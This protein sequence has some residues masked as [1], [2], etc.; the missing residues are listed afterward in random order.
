MTLV[1][2][3]SFP[4]GTGTLLMSLVGVLA[5]YAAC[6]RGSSSAPAPPSEPFVFN[7]PELES[8]PEEEPEVPV[9]AR[10]SG[11]KVA[12]WNVEW[13]HR[14]NGRGNVPRSDEDYAAL[15]RYADM[16]DADVIALQEVDGPEA[17]ARLFDP[18]LYDFAFSSRRSEQLVG[19]A[20]RKG[21]KVEVHPEVTALQIDGN[22]RLRRGVDVSVGEGAQRVRLL[23]VHL[24]S[25]CW[26]T[27]LES[28]EVRRGEDPASC[29]TL[30][31]QSDVLK[32]W[33][34]KRRAAREPFVIL[35]DFNRRLKKGESFWGAIQRDVDD[36]DLSAP[37]TTARSTCK[38]G[39]YPDYI[40]HL[41]L[42]ERVVNRTLLSS[43]TQQI[44]SSEDERRHRDTLSD[45]CPIRVTLFSRP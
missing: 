24:K 30:S 32:A 33:A 3:P 20:Y 9:V 38:G 18:D 19:F 28:A 6:P 17:A 36:V 4:L 5:F 1:K 25:R 34:D 29:R 31:A 42:D 23:G 35:G 7:A 43:F 45:H 11:L 41:V 21:L 15:K 8:E 44:F 37:T 22:R 27:P 26:S 13:L 14:A 2:S 39:R 16:L 40:D 10:S 12:S